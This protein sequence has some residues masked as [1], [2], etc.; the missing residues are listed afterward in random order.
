MLKLLVATLIA[1]LVASTNSFIYLPVAIKPLPMPAVTTTPTVTVT[2]T[3]IP[4]VTATVVPIPRMIDKLFEI[5]AFS[6]T[7]NVTITV[8]SHLGT[9]FANH[10]PNE[11]AA[12][13]CMSTGTILL[14]DGRLQTGM[15]CWYGGES[16]FRFVIS[17]TCGDAAEG[18]I[19]GNV[20]NIFGSI[21]GVIPPTP[22]DMTIDCT[23][24]T[25]TPL[26]TAT[27]PPP[28][29]TIAVTVRTPDPNA[30]VIAIPPTATSVP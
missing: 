26:P 21:I 8:K 30:T 15:H 4:T 28:A 1:A 12:A 3:P 24:P 18:S 16:P 5:G 22:L 7:T 11:N 20:Q 19:E 27:A 29:P 13:T 9:G 2:A 17:V 6:G 23:S 14:P 10:W 25:A